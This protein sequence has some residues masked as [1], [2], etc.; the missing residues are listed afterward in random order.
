[1]LLTM[2]Y[3]KYDEFK[4]RENDPFHFNVIFLTNGMRC[5]FVVVDKVLPFEFKNIRNSRWGVC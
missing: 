2:S 5:L 1:M 3:V 4:L